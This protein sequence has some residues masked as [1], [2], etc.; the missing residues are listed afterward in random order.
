VCKATVMDRLLTK[1]RNGFLSL[2]L[3]AAAWARPGPGSCDEMWFVQQKDHFSWAPPAD[4]A[5]TFLQRWFLCTGQA[6]SW[7]ATRAK[8]RMLTGT[9]AAEF[10]RDAG[11]PPNPNIFYYFG[12]EDD[13]ELYVNNTGEPPFSAASGTLHF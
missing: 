8:V 1:M 3:V 10:W 6:E 12:N 5:S 9:G 4:A 13:V 2:L 7:G 11:S